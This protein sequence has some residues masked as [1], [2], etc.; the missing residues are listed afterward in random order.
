M[1][2]RIPDGAQVAFELEENPD[3]SRWALKIARS[4]L[5][6]NQ[7]LALVKVKGL[8]PLAASRLINPRLA[9]APGPRR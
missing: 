6:P 8:A 5:G 1:E 4:Q 2:E 7:R 3:F 9:L